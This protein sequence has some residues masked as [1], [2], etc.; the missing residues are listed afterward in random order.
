VHFIT[1]LRPFVKWR[2]RSLINPIIHI[3]NAQTDIVKAYQIYHVVRYILSFII[4]VV[5]VRSNLTSSDLGNY[6]LIIFIVSTLTS[7]WSIGF[8]NALL[9]YYENCDDNTKDGLLQVVFLILLSVSA[10]FGLI[11]TFFPAILTLV[12]NAGISSSHTPYIASLLLISAPLMLIENILLLRKEARTLLNFTIFNLVLSTAVVTFFAVFY[13]SLDG[14]LWCLLVVSGIKFLYLLYLVWHGRCIKWPAALVS[15]FMIFSIPAILS[16]LT[17]SAMDYVDGWFV[18]KYFDV[19]TFAIFR[20]GSRELPLSS[21]L[22]AS[23]SAALTPMLMANGFFTQV[24]KQ[25]ATYLMHFMFPASILL[26]ITSPFIFENIYSPLFR[27]S[28]FIFN[29]YLLILTSRVLIPQA[30]NYAKQQ[31]NIV[32]LS[33]IIEL[34]ANIILSYWWMHLWGV[35]GLAFATV[36]AN[37]IQKFILILYNKS[38]NNIPFSYYIDVKYYLSYC[39]LAVLA[40]FYSLNYML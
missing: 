35:Y 19:Q 8:K 7:F 6:E 14:F 9:S 22:F 18:S 24:L 20:Y 11:I 4:S 36:V 40:L 38:F 39:L 16:V 17:G 21:V 34:I 13:S 32:F 12:F 26:M 30:V 28:A 10:I 3:K 2:I 33:G 37:F 5:L 25:K 31:F 15:T 1:I 23:L 27:Q 29:I